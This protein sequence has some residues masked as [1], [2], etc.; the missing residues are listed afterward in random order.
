M[1]PVSINVL[2]LVVLLDWNVEVR[3]N[4]LPN[5]HGITLMTCDQ[6]WNLCAETPGAANGTAAFNGALN[7]AVVVRR[8]WMGNGQGLSLHGTT[9]DCVVEGC[10]LQ[11]SFVV[12]R[13]D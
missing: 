5:S 10:V 6:K 12:A 9:S 1:V 4:R 7:S 3:D 2:L 11:R 13:A 8:N